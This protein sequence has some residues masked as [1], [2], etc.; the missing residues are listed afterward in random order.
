MYVLLMGGGVDAHGKN[1]TGHHQC[2]ECWSDVLDWVGDGFGRFMKGIPKDGVIW[3][4]V[5]PRMD[6]SL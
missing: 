1:E 5:Q 2:D 6:D 4:Y 3:T